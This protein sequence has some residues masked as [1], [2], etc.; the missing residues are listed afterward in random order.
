MEFEEG[1]VVLVRYPAP[2]MTYETSRETWPWYPGTVEEV[3]G[4]DEWLVAVESR[5]VATLEDGTPAPAD[6]NEEDVLYPMCFR[7]SS[8]IRGA[9]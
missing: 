4:P 1:A 7:D 2:G 5:D 3:C 6:A 9:A 8:E